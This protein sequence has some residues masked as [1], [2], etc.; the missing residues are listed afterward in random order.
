MSIDENSFGLIEML[1]VFGIILALAVRE[2]VSVRRALRQ[3]EK[4]LKD[5]KQVAAIRASRGV[6]RDDAPRDSS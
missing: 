4:V 3:D 5:E 1:L 2:L 6:A